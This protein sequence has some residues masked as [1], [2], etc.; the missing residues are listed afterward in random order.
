MGT[1]A[2]VYAEA[3]C[4][5]WGAPGAARRRAA[6]SECRA[7][8]VRSAG[9]EELGV[10]GQGSSEC[11]AW[12]ALSRCCLGAGREYFGTNVCTACLS[13]ERNNDEEG[14]LEA[15]TGAEAGVWAGAGV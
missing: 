2:G 9:P 14:V 12:G 3:E 4:R 6:L 10:Q 15:S 11:R 13:A 5:A 1:G 7:W 8:G